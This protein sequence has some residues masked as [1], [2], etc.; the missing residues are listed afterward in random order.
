M[1]WLSPLSLIFKKNVPL[2]GIENVYL[3]LMTITQ[4][5][6]EFNQTLSKSVSLIAVSKTKPIPDLLVAYQAGQRAFGENKIQEMTEK[7]EQIGRA[8][9]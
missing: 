5:I 6:I 4:N 7:W 1:E 9:V 8:H 3:H 2:N